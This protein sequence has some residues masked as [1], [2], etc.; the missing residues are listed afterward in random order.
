MA[1]TTENAPVVEGQPAQAAPLD[2]MTRVLGF[3][4]R[5]EARLTALE[6]RQPAQFTPMRS[7][8]DP[9]KAEI[10]TYQPPEALMKQSIK[11]LTRDGQQTSGNRGPMENP[12]YVSKLPPKYRPVFRSGARV[13]INPDAVVHGTATNADGPV[14][15]RDALAKVKSPGDGEILAIN[16]MRKTWE[17]KY[18]V[19]VRGLTP[20]RGDGFSES[21]LLPA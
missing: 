3:M 4:E 15:W 1:T 12:E 2:P 14:S 10:G 9:R 21:E 7:E 20:A 6:E 8:E 13:R 19:F 11:G 5:M 18:T 17:P 16:Y